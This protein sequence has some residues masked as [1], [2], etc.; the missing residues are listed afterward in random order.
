MNPI[1]PKG[2]SRPKGREFRESGIISPIRKWVVVC[3]AVTDVKG[4]R[5][6]DGDETLVIKENG[7]LRVGSLSSSL[8]YGTGI[9]E[10]RKTEEG[11][12]IAARTGA[13]KITFQG[14]K[15]EHSSDFSC[16]ASMIEK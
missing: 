15:S 6:C 14:V 13:C 3:V 8:I 10:R 9:T 5:Y 12:C 4:K 1:T 11:R 7:W 16:S 2:Y